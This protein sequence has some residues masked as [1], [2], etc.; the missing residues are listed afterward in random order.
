[1]ES[2][3]IKENI[4]GGAMKHVLGY[5]DGNPQENMAKLLAWADRFDRADLFPSQRK[6]FHSILDDPNG[7]WYRLIESLWTDIDPDVRKKLFENFFVNASLVGMGRQEKVKKQCGCNVPWAILLDPTSSCNLKCTG[8]WAADY[9]HALNLSYETI[10]DII[11]QGKELGT[12]MY[13]YSG[14][15]PLV[16]K[17]DIIRL[18]EEHSDCVFL[19]FT[20]GTLID[21]EFAEEVLRVGNFVPAISVEGFEAATDFRRGKGTY[22]AVMRAME[23]LKEKKLPFGASAAIRARTSIH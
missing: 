17:K 6:T 18:C 2:S 15:E 8:C 5:L 20:N 19:A 22:R 12:F 11:R 16:R 7:N 23:I 10:D 9:N 3:S 14:G 13:I 21:E 4:K 1:M